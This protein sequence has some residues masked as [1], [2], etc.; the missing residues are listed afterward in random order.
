MPDQSLTQY[1]LSVT[2][3]AATRRAF[4]HPFLTHAGRGTVPDE[5]L[6]RWLAQDTHYTRAYTRFIGQTVGGLRLPFQGA[7]SGAR[8][9]EFRVLDVLVAALNGIQRETMFFEETAAQYG[10]RLAHGGAA[11]EPGAAA[12][13]YRRL[14]ETVGS[15]ASSHG[16]RGGLIRAL[17]LL[18]STEHA[19]LTSW[20]AAQKAGADAAPAS[21]AAAR[22]LREAFIPNWTNDAFEEFVA[23]CAKI[24]DDLAAEEG[25]LEDDARKEACRGVWA[26]VLRIEE[27]F[28]PHMETV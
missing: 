26:E 6:E 25:V 3:P 21:S 8:A 9:L 10:L 11:P 22:A 14:F 5:L 28:W 17:V 7:T 19:Y 27:A 4:E 15:E 20:R 1:L 16:D 24:V 23:S 18:W 2:D 12:Q 13:D